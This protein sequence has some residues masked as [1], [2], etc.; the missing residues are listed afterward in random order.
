MPTEQQ[1]IA[2]ERKELMGLLADIPLRSVDENVVIASWNIAQ[3]SNRKKVRALQYIADI[4][5]RFDI[6]AIQEVKTNLQ[7]LSKLQDLLPGNYQILV[8]DPTGNFER[9]A[10]LYDKRT[11]ISTG[12]VCEIAFNGTI[13][14][15]EVFQF[16]RT[17][18]C[19]SFRAGRFDFTMV[20]VHIA[21][22][23][24]LQEVGLAVRKREI[25][26]LVSFIKR[27]ASRPQGSVFDPDFF[28]VG[29]FNIQS[30]GDLFFQ[31]LT[32]GPEPRFQM[33]PG[34]NTLGTNFDQTKTFDKIAWIPSQEFKFSGKFGVIPFG[35]VL[36][37]EPGQP[38]NAARMEVSDHL[39]LWAEFR[40][41]ELEYELNQILNRER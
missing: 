39:P 4:C 3:F 32:G 8:S 24:H 35:K 26:E 21:E 7:G 29:D 34:M 40:V 9:L 33:P 38:P 14:S 30:D 37:K 22:G 11:V 1:I 23:S 31:A 5:E 27:E 17:P 13:S 36:Y 20:S 25:E 12:L 6:I 28:L 41:T 18:Y 2:A 10:F 19:A 16:Q 15:P